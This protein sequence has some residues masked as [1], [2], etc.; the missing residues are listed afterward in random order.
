MRFPLLALVH[1]LFPCQGR[2]VQNMLMVPF[3]FVAAL[4]FPCEMSKLLKTILPH[5]E[6]WMFDTTEMC[7]FWAELVCLL[8]SARKCFPF[9]ISKVY[10][11]LWPWDITTLL[12]YNRNRSSPPPRGVQLL[13]VLIADTGTFSRAKGHW[14][15]RAVQ[16]PTAAQAPCKHS[17]RPGTSV[18]PLSHLVEVR[19]LHHPSA[20]KALKS[21]GGLALLPGFPLTGW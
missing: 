14:S 15:W 3:F 8:T 1:G 12:G 13:N 19:C 4:S 20:Y 5:G 2:A 21:L 18:Q 6:P 17:I 16:M 11:S 9:L 10:S 7:R